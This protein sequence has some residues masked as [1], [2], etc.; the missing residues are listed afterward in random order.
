MQL[1]K[2][3]F[4]EI[5]KKGSKTFY[6]VSLFFPKE[7][8][9]DVFLLYAFTRTADDFVDATPPET[10]KFQEYKQLT[11][12]ALE[13]NTVDHPV[14]NA[15][16]ELVRRRSINPNLVWDYFTA[17]DMDVDGRRYG[18]YQN[19]EVYIYGVAETIGLMMAKIMELP[20][21]SYQSARLLGK[22]FQLINIIRDID[23]DEKLGREYIPQDDLG[24]FGLAS[25]RDGKN[26]EQR[27]RKLIRF[28]LGRFL[29]VNKEA[30]KGLRFLPRNYRVPISTASDVFESV[31]KKIYR[32]PMIIF[33]E[34]VK[35]SVLSILCTVFR[36]Y[37][38]SW[39]S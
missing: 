34:K 1:N 18:S 5:T 31:G 39:K 14:V 32:D 24:R 22:A 29:K 7:I 20:E 16:G 23:E 37:V 17:L 15:F 35:P 25:I 30:K 10:Q 27:M 3:L 9:Y 8:R 13:G 21:E 19:L 33:R 12:S 26:Q 36:N 6:S 28:E 11:G 4:E 2:T 38:F